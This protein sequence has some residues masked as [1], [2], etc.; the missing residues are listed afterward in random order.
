MGVLLSTCRSL[1]DA[2]PP[3]GPAVSL[4]ARGTGVRACARPD[5]AERPAG[6]GV[7][8]A[9]ADGPSATIAGAH[10]GPAPTAESL[11]AT[12]RT[13]PAPGTR[14]RTTAVART[15]RTGGATAGAKPLLDTIGR[16]GPL[17]PG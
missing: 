9:L 8:G 2:E 3:L 14:A 12:L 11:P 7:A 17:M 13:G 1:G 10:E 6:V 16:E 15:I 4:R 5:S